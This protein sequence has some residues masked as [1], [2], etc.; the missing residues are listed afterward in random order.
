[1]LNPQIDY[2]GYLALIQEVRPYR[3]SRLID[4]QTF[5]ALADEPDVLIL[6]ARSADQFAAGHIAAS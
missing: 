5:I 4:W 1:M 3:Q 2:D 6:D